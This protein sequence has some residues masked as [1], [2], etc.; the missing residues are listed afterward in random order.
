MQRT[1]PAF[2]VALLLVC[3]ISLSLPARA[4]DL[5]A[6]DQ[7][8]RSTLN[9]HGV[10]GGAFAVV[11]DGKIEKIG[12]FG[13]RRV[14]TQA[15]VT[16]TT[17]FRT[18]SVSKTFAAQLT[19]IVVAEGH[20]R[21]EDPVVRFVPELRM[22]D[23]NHAGKLQLHHL[24]S[25]T[26]GI[27]PNAFD[28]LLSANTPL[29]GIVPHFANVQPVCAPGSCYTYQNVLFALVEP[30]IE[31][32][33]GRRFEDLMRERLLEPLG[34]HQASLGREAFLA[35]MDRASPHVRLAQGRVWTAVE[36]AES[37]YLVPS[38]AGVNA[39]VLD[40]AQWLIAQ[41]GYRPDVLDPS[42]IEPLKEK[43]VRTERELRRG[44]WGPMLSDAHYGLGW[45]IL[46][47]GQEPIFTH[48]GWVRGFVAHVSYSR[49]RR[50]GLVVMLNGESRALGE[51]SSAFWREQLAHPHPQL[52]AD[53]AADAVKLSR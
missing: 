46:T 53:S 32:S 17:V 4:D 13:V 3:T 23:P 24:L 50:T 1:T 30:A 19:A 29:A 36:V 28:N 8:F 26:T 34:M 45:R 14:G 21:W 7:H 25:Q 33:T 43:R 10:P 42:L 49:D 9:E 22:Q 20:L 38:A 27:V 52:V 31:Q 11:R 48:N 41:T 37:F 35:E 5:A 40:L 51:I 6:F 18:A 44:A 47:V 15:P 39:S 16:A 2:L 12:T